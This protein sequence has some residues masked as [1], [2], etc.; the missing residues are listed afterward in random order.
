MAFPRRSRRMW[1]QLLNV[2]RQAIQLP[3]R[4]D[5]ARGQKCKA[6]QPMRMQIAEN[7][8][9]DAQAPRIQCASLAAVDPGLHG[10]GVRMGFVHLA[11]E[12]GHLPIRADLRL[13]HALRPQRTKPTDRWCPFEAH[14]L[15]ALDDG[16]GRT[17]LEQASVWAATDLA[18][19]VIF[20]V[21]RLKPFRAAFSRH[22]L[23]VLG[24]V[25][26]RFGKARIA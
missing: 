13:S 18:P 12:E 20:E 5:F 6:G 22:A 11:A 16:V 26:I 9:D 3:L 17:A 14:T 10:L 15:A 1:N 24:L 4:V 7:G 2:M 21:L 25:W 23:L 8:L 19:G